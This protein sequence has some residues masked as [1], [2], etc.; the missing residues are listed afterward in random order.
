MKTLSAITVAL[1]CGVLSAVEIPIVNSRFN[2]EK[3]K[4]AR[5][6]LMLPKDNSVTVES[7]PYE[8]QGVNAVKIT[9]TKAEGYY[10]IAQGGF[11]LK[12]FPRPAADEELQ[13]TISFRQKNVNV[14]KGAFAN[15]SFFSDKGYLAGR[16]TPRTSGT[17]EWGDMETTVKFKEF[18]AGAKYF[19]L[20][21]FMGPTTG[22]AYFAE[23]KLYVNAVKKAK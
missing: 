18:P 19:I 13:I 16:D 21:F 6:Q 23:P 7:V 11:D 20:R 10:G 9:S 14:G 15:V 8:V 5:W 17:F 4:I 1:L 22:T 2:V 12:K 3:G